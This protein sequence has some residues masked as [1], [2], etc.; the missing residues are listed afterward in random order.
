MSA[1][2][3]TQFSAQHKGKEIHIQ[4]EACLLRLSGHHEP[5]ISDIVVH[6]AVYFPGVLACV[7]VFGAGQPPEQRLWLLTAS[8]L[9]PALLLIDHG[10]FQYNCI[11]LG[12]AVRH[13]PPPVDS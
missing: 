11:S 13:L 2:S 12:L 3:R 5:G 8:L 6:A 4:C 10:H 7:A 9:Q 1:T